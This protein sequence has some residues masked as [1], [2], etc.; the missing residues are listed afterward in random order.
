VLAN[1][2]AY[3]SVLFD[4]V[5]IVLALLVAYP[6]PGG[7]PALARGATIL[8]IVATLLMVGT[9]IGGDYY[10]SGID[11]T[12]SLGVNMHSTRLTVLTHAAAWTGIVAVAA[13]C[14]AA[15]GW[16]AGDRRRAR[17]AALLAVAALIVPA[18]QALQGAVLGLDR[19]IVA[20]AWFAAMAAGY[21]AHRLIAAG[22]GPQARA[23]I[24]GACAAALLFPL[25]LGVSQSQALLRSWPSS[26]SNVTWLWTINQDRPGTGPIAS[27][28]PGAKYVTWVGID[29]YYFRRSDTFASVFGSTIHQVR[30]L[31]GKPILL[32]ETA[33]GP[34]AGQFTKI[35]DLFSEMR[36]YRTLGLV[37]FDKVQNDGIY[38][39]D[40]RIENDPQADAAFR[41]GLSELSLA[42]P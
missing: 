25:T 10:V 17:L 37:W 33:V 6:K 7:K 32:S 21:A 40:W 3:S 9:L 31:T 11:Q 36:Q 35:S 15:M 4:P 39:Q 41:L 1:A 18:E 30:D 8:T 34:R 22:A 23:V 13:L 5:V 29:G 42:R 27:W 14:A 28:W 26:A 12:L 20:G 16:A 24:G 38:H 19:H 2:A